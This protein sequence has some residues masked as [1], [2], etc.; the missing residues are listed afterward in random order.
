MRY[1]E[2]LENIGH[3]VGHEIKLETEKHPGKLEGVEDKRDSV[4]GE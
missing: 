3:E 4:D 1:I 2:A